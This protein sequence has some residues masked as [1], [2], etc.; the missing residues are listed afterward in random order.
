MAR[1]AFSLRAKEARP[2]HAAGVG[3]NDDQ[4]LQLHL[5]EM[6]DED[7]QGHQVVDRDVEEALDLGGVQVDG[8]DPRETG[9]FQQV[10]QQP[11]RDG[12]PRPV[13]AVLAGVGVVGDHGGDAPR[14]G[15]LEGVGHQQQFHDVE[16][17]VGAERLDDEDVGAADVLVALEAD[18]AVGENVQDRLAE[19]SRAGWRRSSSAS[20]S[21]DEPEKSRNLLL[22]IMWF[23]WGG[24]IRTSECRLQRPMPYHLATPQSSPDNIFWRWC[25]SDRMPGKNSARAANLSCG[26]KPNTAE[27]LPVICTKSHP[28]RDILSLI[29]LISGNNSKVTFSSSFSK[30]EKS[31]FL[32]EEL[33]FTG[34]MRLLSSEIGK[35]PGPWIRA[36]AGMHKAMAR[37]RE[38]RQRGQR[39]PR[40]PRPAPC[41][42]RRKNGTSAPRPVAISFISGGGDAPG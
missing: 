14:R 32:Q 38:R 41:R 37:G 3:G 22:L 34:K 4:V 23:F 31:P 6:G 12:H 7:R 33:Y 19:L 8:Q 13:L 28:P 30:T 27:P 35:K 20:F 16:V 42:R 11:G 18:L 21:L 1:S 9:G 36:T 10:G 40:S 29:S 5:L 2:L 39:S 25:G 26:P 24:R 17:A 15:A